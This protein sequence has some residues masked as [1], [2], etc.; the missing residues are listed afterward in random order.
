[1]RLGL[2][3]RRGS[4]AFVLAAMLILAGLCRATGFGADAAAD[5]LGCDGQWAQTPLCIERAQALDSRARIEA[6]L[7]SLADVQRPPWPPGDLVAASALY[8]EGVALFRDEYFGDAAVKFEPALSQLEAI[9]ESFDDLVEDTLAEA[10]SRLVGEDFSGALGGFAQVLAWIPDHGVALAGATRAE[11][12]QGLV[13]TAERAIALV[14]A[15]DAEGARALLD[16][17]QSDFQPR[18]LRRAQSA[19]QA[20]NARARLNAQITAGHAAL[21]RMAWTAAAEAFRSALAIDA[22]STAAKDGLAQAQRGAVESRLVSLRES[23]A[24]QLDDESWAASVST[25]RE[26]GK[27]RPD[28]PEVR[29]RLPELERLAALEARLDLALADPTRAA[30]KTMR[31]ESRD[32]IASAAD[33]DL[34]GERIHVKGEQLKRQFDKWTTAVPLTIHSDSRT[35]IQIRPGRKLGRF[36]TTN[37]EVFPG[38]YT[39][40]ARREGFREK[41]VALTVE[42]ESRPII[43]ELI[44]DERF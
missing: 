4:P 39:L 15:G 10:E 42:P 38:R 35:E 31:E 44:C 1:M 24:G 5:E 9:Q 23:L 19:L 6:I 36:R 16:G 18:A 28:A 7:S 25:A 34:V 30:A 14:K 37:L 32:L 41:M 43:V 40:V 27:L 3:T 20:F 2:R 12:G 13:S 33:R 29:L 11:T 21:D 17:L 22:R 8:D 26:I